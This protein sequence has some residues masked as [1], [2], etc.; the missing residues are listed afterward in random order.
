MII[1]TFVLALTI[2]CLVHAEEII[3]GVLTF[4]PPAG[5]DA[6]KPGGDPGDNPFSGVGQLREYLSHDGKQID[7]N[8]RLVGFSIGQG[9]RVTYRQLGDAGVKQE[10]VTLA[11][12]LQNV[13]NMSAIAETKLG[14]QKALS[15]TF[16]AINGI[17]F[18]CDLYWVRVDT[19]RVLE[20]ELITHSDAA[21]VELRQSLPGFKIK[22]SYSQ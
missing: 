9:K 22:K 11:K 12:S 15:F 13:T 3:P 17:H 1:R 4:T 8:M 14:G 20:V 7:I 18:Y 16:H 21:L 5:F 6:F 19:N 2:T 10:M